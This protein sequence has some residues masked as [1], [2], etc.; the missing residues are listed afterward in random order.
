[1]TTL[2]EAFRSVAPGEVEHVLLSSVARIVSGGTPK[3]GEA[4]FWNGDVPWVTPKDLSG[5]AS[6]EIHSTSRLITEAGLRNSSAEI[7]PENSVLF[8]SRAPIGLLAIN[9]TPMATNQGFKSFVPDPEK[10]DSRY[11]FRWLE[12]N[13]ARL[14]NMGVGA[15]FKEVSKAIVS[16]LV[17]PLPSL[18]EQQR[19]A[20]ILDKADELRTKR[21]QA[22]A[23]LDVLTQSVFDDAQKLSEKNAVPLAELCDSIQTGPFG[24][25]LHR[26]DYIQ[27]GV[28]LINPMHIVSGQVQASP[29]YSVASTKFEELRLYHLEADDIVL[30]RRGEM[31]RCALVLAAQLPLLCGTGSMIVR[32]DSQA[33]SPRYLQQVLSSPSIRRRLE[34]ASQGVTMSNLNGKILSGLRVRMPKLAIQREFSNRYVAIDRLRTRQRAQL[35][36][37]DALFASLQNR[38]FKAEL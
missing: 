34:D 15:T 30:A 36:E 28:P 5:L 24:S 20:G 21:R 23:H 8:S 11:L 2:S 35:D 12:A 29:D 9:T 4:S 38:A 10:L 19:I 18:D 3:T 13:R 27:N 31:G 32:P 7:L 25:L 33:V 26:E 6:V 22:L 1:M 37:L 14:Q 17:I 16:R